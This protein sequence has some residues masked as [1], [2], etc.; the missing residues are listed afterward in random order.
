MPDVQMAA[1]ENGVDKACAD[2]TLEVTKLIDKLKEDL[3]ACHAK[4]GKRIE[5]VRA[6][7]S[8]A[9]KDFA[10]LPDAVNVILAQD[11]A[12]LKGIVDLE[13]VFKADA[14]AKKLS[15]QGFA[16]KGKVRDL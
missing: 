5:G 7:Q 11:S 6:P 1:F 3:R 10:K 13:L 4:L 12:R 16:L 2:W 8:L 14:K 15:Y 9:D